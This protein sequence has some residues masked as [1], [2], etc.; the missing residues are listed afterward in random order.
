V[1]ILLLS[2]IL[3]LPAVVHASDT[4]TLSTA[5]ISVLRPPEGLIHPATHSAWIMGSVIWPKRP[6][7]I[8]GTSVMP[9]PSGGFLAYLP[10]TPGTFTF[11]CELD[12]PDG[13][14]A[15][16]NRTIFV[17]PPLQASSTAQT[18]I[19]PEMMQPDKDLELRPG[20]WL[21][22]QMKGPPGGQ[23]EFQIQGKRKRFPMASN[24]LGIYKGAYQIQSDDL[25]ESSEIYF[26]LTGP[27]KSSTWTRAKGKLTVRAGSPSVVAVKSNGVVNVR[28][29]VG[30]GFFLYPPLGTKFLAVGRS[31]AETKVQLSPTLEGWIDTGTL[32]TL[33]AGTPPPHAILDVL[34]TSGTLDSTIVY[35]GLT[36][37][38]PFEIEPDDHL[39]AL[40]IRLFYTSGGT[41]WMIYDSSDTYVQEVRWRQETSDT[42]VVTIRLDPRSK[43]WGWHASWEGGALKIELRHPPHFS[44]YGSVFAGRTIVLDPGHMPSAPGEI[45]PR[46]LLEKDANLAI[47]KALEHLLYRE[48]AKP[49]MTRSGDDEVGLLERPRIAW[50]NRG[51][52]FVSIHNNG[53]PYGEDPFQR[54]AGFQI[55]YYYPMSLPLARAVHHS[56]LKRIPLPDGKLRYG[57]LLVARTTEM[58]AILVESAYMT[59]PEQE[60]LLATPSFQRKL[61]KA[62]LEGLRDFLESERKRQRHSGIANFQGRKT[63]N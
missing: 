36:D 24:P 8:N 55:F 11:H 40:N 62:M 46:G 48:G 60:V 35:L 52:I 12:L 2:L 49:V 34:R 4:V 14:T 3:A 18:R 41:D 7:R 22:V 13:T 26:Y 53:L 61:A 45:G 20:D 28:T 29:A 39:D 23:A 63:R 17:L 59:Y 1:L 42:A 16:L 58:P 10:I 5:P 57:N 30:E 56:Y 43:I 25:L 9:H 31:G 54:P 37:A 6:F 15:F 33:Q 19:E 32:Q 27:N 44:A 38:V 50:E 47:A 21:V 51:D